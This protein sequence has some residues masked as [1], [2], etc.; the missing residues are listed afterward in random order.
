MYNEVRGGLTHFRGLHVDA[1]LTRDLV[2]RPGEGIAG[3]AFQERRPV[4]S[5]DVLADPLVRYYTPATERLIRT[6]AARAVLAAPMSSR[7]E[8]HGVLRSAFFLSP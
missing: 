8:V 2:L 6:R 4:W 5:S 3:R 7:D 1:E